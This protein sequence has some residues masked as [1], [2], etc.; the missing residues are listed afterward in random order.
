MPS[1][2]DVFDDEHLPEDYDGEVE[3]AGAMGQMSHELG[4]EGYEPIPPVFKRLHPNL[5]PDNYALL[6]VCV[7]ER[8]RER[9]RERESVCVCVCI[10][11]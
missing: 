2:E 6:K 5:T 8:E 1:S 11:R 7:T 10:D 4:W 3:M 9:E